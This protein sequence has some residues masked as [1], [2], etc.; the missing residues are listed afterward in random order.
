M[1][2]SRRDRHRGGLAVCRTKTDEG[3]N[4]T[5]FPA[6]RSGKRIDVVAVIE[7]YGLLAFCAVLVLL[8][9]AVSPAFRSS[10]NLQNVLTNVA[11]L[12][13]VVLGQSMVILVRGFDLSVS[14]LATAAVI[15]TRFESSGG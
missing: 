5:P 13:I 3:M 12:A 2:D 11:P 15:A 1:D 14:S 9:A 4:T 6:E 7:R 10:T 8:T